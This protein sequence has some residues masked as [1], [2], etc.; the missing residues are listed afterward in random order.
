MSTETVEPIAPT[1]AAPESIAPKPFV[2]QSAMPERA[3]EPTPEGAATTTPAPAAAPA[4]PPAA[5]LVQNPPPA[6][7]AAGIAAPQ[8]DT[9]R[10]A[11]KRFSLARRLG[12]FTAVTALLWLGYFTWRPPAPMLFLHHSEHLGNSNQVALTFDDAPHPLSTPLLL[13]AL[14]RSEVKASFF[15]VG[16]GL[17]IYPELSYRMVK[18]GHMLANHSENHRNLTSIPVSEYNV[19]VNTCFKRIEALGQKTRLFRPPGGGLNR[20]AM[21]HLYDNGY[22]LAWWSNN[23]G[24]WVRPPA[25]RVVKNVN[26]VLKPGDIVLLH[27]AGIGT[28]QALPVIVRNAR[29]NG[30]EFVPMPEK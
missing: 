29:E 20:E 10:E 8:S 22:T 9:A 15:V 18:E 5:P 25:W 23:I 7:D 28:A 1:E 4:T 27:D 24:D 14:K 26:D 21:Q 11:A 17:R 12:S 16:E 30:L 13:A 19:E 2:P 3:P 6:T